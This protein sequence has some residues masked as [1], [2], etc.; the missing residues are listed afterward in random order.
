[1]KKILIPI[2]ALLLSSCHEVPNT[3]TEVDYIQCYTCVLESTSSY[4][5]LREFVDTC[6][7]T[8][9]V[10]K[11]IQSQSYTTPDIHVTMECQA[12]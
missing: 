1:M 11:Y 8:Q 12:R 3:D 5:T 2:L 4:C 10:S 6:M 9:Q 7:L